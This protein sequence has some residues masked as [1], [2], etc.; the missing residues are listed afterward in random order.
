MLLA[1][2]A[3]AASGV[4]AVAVLAVVLPEHMGWLCSEQGPFEVISPWAWIGLAVAIPIIFREVT[5]EVVAGMV[6]CGGGA[7]REWDWHV[8]FTG[9]SVLK[10]PF[11]YREGLLHE[12]LIAGAAVLLAL[13]SLVVL[14][15]W[16][17]SLRPWARPIKPWVWGTVL[18]I[19]MMLAS[20]VVDR[21]PAILA[22]DFGLPLG[23]VAHGVFSALE[24]SV[25]MLVPFFF[26]L[27][28]VSLAFWLH[29]NEE[30]PG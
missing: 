6:V 27:A 14:V 30:E 7:A 1:S 20:K 3:L 18:A 5:L 22:E 15:R 10:P 26:G 21:A 16:Q 2:I 12:R 19:G 9:Y 28:C 17:R 4:A 11:Y 24:E 13:A 8:R 23:T 29:R 25:E